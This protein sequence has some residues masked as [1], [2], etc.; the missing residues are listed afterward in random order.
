V[1][2]AL[3]CAHPVVINV[4]LV[5][6][7]RPLA[8]THLSAWGWLSAFSLINML[9]LVAANVTWT[10]VG[11]RADRIDG[12]LK[13]SPRSGD[14]AAWL[15]R[16]LSARQ[17]LVLPS[18]GCISSAMFLA[19]IGPHLNSIVEIGAASYV[20]VAFTSFIGGN[21]C[22][23]L[24]VAPGLPKKMFEAGGLTTR[25]QD[26]ASTPGI[27]LVA[28]G[29]GLSALFLLG[30]AIGISVAGFIVPGVTR[31]PAL[32]YLLDAFFVLV[33]ATSVR[34]GIYPFIWVYAIVAGAKRESLSRLNT[35]VPNVSHVTRGSGKE[36]G[37]AVLTLYGQVSAAPNM[38]FST[39]ALVQYGAT[40]VGTALAFATSIAV[41]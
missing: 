24:W 30:G 14:V 40:L 9:M 41:R 6:L 27:R 37:Y 22:Y 12:I 23:W 11:G 8:V 33:F 36:K 28:E 7:D 2:L 13:S 34:V 25:W 31:L 35:L 5:W 1:V 4:V 26:P 38:P 32:N 39:A 17:Q 29:L 10:F 15:D 18:A 20:S 16:R 21:V 19:F 3:L